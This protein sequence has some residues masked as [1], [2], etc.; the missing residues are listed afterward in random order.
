M[1]RKAEKK[2]APRVLELLR[3]IAALHHAGRPDIFSG[4]DPKYDEAALCEKFGREN[5]RIFVSVD[6]NDRVN[7][8]VMCVLQEKDEPLYTQR[9]YRTLYVDDLRVDKA[10]RRKG[11]GRALM[12]RAVEEARALKCYHLDLNVWACNEDAIRFYESIG[13]QKERQ[14]MEMILA[15][16]F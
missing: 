10:A 2:D 4:A 5:E 15:D 9:P 7:G 13:M 3:E 14:Y 6:E 1:I 12:A 11:V 16:R 8:Y